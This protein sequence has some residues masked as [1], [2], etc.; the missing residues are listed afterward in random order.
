MG[1]S[2]RDFWPAIKD[3]QGER[4]GYVWEKYPQSM[5]HSCNLSSHLLVPGPTGPV[6]S[7]RYEEM[8]EGLQECEARI[9]IEQVLTDDVLRKKLGPDLASR[10]QQLLDDRIWQMQKA[11]SNMQLTGL[12]YGTY[13]TASHR[14]YYAYGGSAGHYWYLSSNWQDNAAKLYTLAGEV[15]RKMSN[16]Q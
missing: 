8:R 11:C 7:T 1:G 13:A 10:A 16:A 5:W 14:W 2:A 3:K 6:A 9:T 15:A 4:R 12:G